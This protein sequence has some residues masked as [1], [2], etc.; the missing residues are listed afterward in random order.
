MSAWARRQA[1]IRRPVIAEEPISPGRMARESRV[2]RAAVRDL[3]VTEEPLAAEGA[4]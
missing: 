2:F 1:S 3:H 4:Q